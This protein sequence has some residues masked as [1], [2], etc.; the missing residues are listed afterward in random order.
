VAK[1]VRE[2]NVT[3]SDQVTTVLSYGALLLLGYLV[4]EIT[5][6]FL[7]PLAWSAV[8]AIFFYPLHQKVLKRFKPN[9]AALLSTL[10]VTVLLIVPALLL[11][12][13]TA[14]QAI[15]AGA[16]A[17]V[18]LQSPDKAVPALILDW[19]KRHLP[20]SLQDVD[21]A[22]TARTGAAKV[23]GF[24][25]AKVGGLVRN[26]F[27]FF[28]DLFVLLFALFFMFRD[29]EDVAR[30]VRHFLPFDAS[31][32]EDMMRESREL[33]FASVA[34]GLLIASIQGALGGLAFTLAGIGTAIFWGVLIAFF[35]LVPVVGS[36]LVWVPAALWLAFTGH[37][38]SGLLVAAICG[39]V[40]G[41]ADNIVRPLLLR[42]RT[43]LNELLLF[44][45]VLGGIEVFGLL[46]LV[47]G[48]TIVAAA[49]GVFRVY[50][51]HRDEL[52]AAQS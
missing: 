39:V 50:M 16:K 2:R 20:D 17:Q 29:G 22:D 43:H 18:V 6:P 5:A 15:D 47:A 33:I 12:F 9:S 25:A 19:V 40:A 37:V 11:L 3:T 38:G 26:I 48:P 49:M 44:I 31:I 24:L 45:S 42:N 7:V 10:G 32:Q 28:L 23:G 36:A 21:L 13:Y 30:A 35:S 8:V 4:Y 27:S 52:E 34:V 14:R 1:T 51:Q 46:G 41:V